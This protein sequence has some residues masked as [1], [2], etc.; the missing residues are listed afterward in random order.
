MVRLVFE[1]VSDTSIIISSSSNESNI[2]I[3]IQN[4]FKNIIVCLILK[5]YQGITLILMQLFQDKSSLS[6]LFTYVACFIIHFK[7][8]ITHK[9]C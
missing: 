8:N 2:K 6:T 5:K 4:F 7:G 3:I 9:K 1:G